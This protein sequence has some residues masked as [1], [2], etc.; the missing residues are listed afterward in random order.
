M[1]PEPL[2]A[3]AVQFS[4]VFLVLTKS[5]EKACDLIAEAAQEAYS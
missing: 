1:F 4:P 2:I 5:L 3:T